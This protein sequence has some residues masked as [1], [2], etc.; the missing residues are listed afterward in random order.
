MSGYRVRRMVWGW[1][2][3]FA[4]MFA[5]V[6]LIV[7]GYTIAAFLTGVLI[8]AAYLQWGGVGVAVAGLLAATTWITTITTLVVDE[9]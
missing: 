4:A 1:L 2:R 7:G 9:G 6:L 5:I 3:R 8:R